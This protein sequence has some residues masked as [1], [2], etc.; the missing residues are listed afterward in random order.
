MRIGGASLDVL[1][2]GVLN[3]MNNS[4]GIM[5]NVDTELLGDTLS[6]INEGRV[7]LIRM[8]ERSVNPNLGNNVDVAV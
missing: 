6:D 2:S 5:L 4:K 3:D 1:T 8:M 7:N